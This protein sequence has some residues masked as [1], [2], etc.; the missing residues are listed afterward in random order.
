MSA[1]TAN[2]AMAGAVI[3]TGLAFLLA[4]V[5]AFSYSRTKAPRLV[6]VTLAFLG[7]VAQ[8]FY[9]AM[10]AYRDRGDIAAGQGG[11]VPTIIAL[12]LA[13]VAFLYLAVLK[14]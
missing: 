4:V 10:I 7:F 9:L 11:P 1:T 2:V 3:L 12:D 5:G 8:G 13:I 14:R 6:W